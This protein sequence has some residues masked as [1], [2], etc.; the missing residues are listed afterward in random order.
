M[1]FLV[2][3][4]FAVKFI[5]MLS[6]CR[7]SGNSKQADGTI[8]NNLAS[9]NESQAP[10]YNLR[11]NDS[12][13]HFEY[14]VANLGQI[15][16]GRKK[17]VAFKFTNVSS[18]PLII[19]RI[20]TT[21]GCTSVNYEKA[22]LMPGKVSEIKVEFNPE[23]TGVFFRKLFVFYAGGDYSIEIAIKGEVI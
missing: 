11:T 4:V 8:F 7:S 10:D 19:T 1:T 3:A 12:L 18:A 21:C 14:Q 20:V 23:E 6:A 5:L 15:K 2:V 16:K 17:D 9:L 22:P 13:F